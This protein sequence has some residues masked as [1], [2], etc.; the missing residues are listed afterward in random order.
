MD[1]PTRNFVKKRKDKLCVKTEFWV[2]DDN[3]EDLLVLTDL[4]MSE[5]DDDCYVI[6]E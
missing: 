6:N 3:C 4:S 5:L 2:I 1:L